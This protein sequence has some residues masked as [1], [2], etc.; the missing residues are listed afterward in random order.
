MNKKSIIGIIFAVI[1]V[2]AISFKIYLDNK[3]EVKEDGIPVAT[4]DSKK[5]KD[6]YESLNGTKNASDIEYLSLSIDEASPVQYKTDEEIVDILNNGTGVIY[7]GF[8]TCPWCRSM[9][10]TLLK[11]VDDNN[12]SNL[13][14]VDIKDI[15][16]SYKVNNSK[17]EK[18]IDGTE[19]YYKILDRLAD[20]L[21]D[22]KIT[23]GKKE[24]DTG[25][26]RLYAP[27]VVAIKNGEILGL[28]EATVESQTDPYS[29]LTDEEA[30]ELYNIYSDMFVELNE[31]TC[32]NK[33][34]GC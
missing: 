2:G 12:V 14:Y 30:K 28:H 1:L 8:S 25:E 31:S 4:A 32:N 26:K 21:S 23:S 24:Y 11:A 29:G 27:T 34:T 7:F 13:Y 15:R 10:E 19:S 33:E 6:E 18:T 3:E 9:V 22:Y 5:F 20:Y 16:S 17:L